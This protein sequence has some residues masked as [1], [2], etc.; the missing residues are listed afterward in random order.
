MKKE[1]FII[2]KWYVSTKWS[3]FIATKFK[4]FNYEGQYT[5]SEVIRGKTSS[6]E[7][8]S[9]YTATDHQEWNTFKEI[10]LAEI[11]KYLPVGHADLNLSSPEY[12]ICI[13]S[14]GLSDYK[15]NHIYKLNNGKIE[16]GAAL[17]RFNTHRFVQTTKE[18]YD[19]QESKLKPV[20]IVSPNPEY[21]KCIKEYAGGGKVGVVY[22]RNGWH[23]SIEGRAIA[24]C[25]HDNP[26]RLKWFIPAT[27]EEYDAQHGKQPVKSIY[28]K[29]LRATKNAESYINK[30]VIYEFILESYDSIQVKTNVTVGHLSPGNILF[31]SSTHFVEATKEQYEAQC[32]PKAVESVDPYTYELCVDTYVGSGV[33]GR[34]YQRKGSRL[35]YDGNYEFD[36]S[37]IGEGRRLYLRSSNKQTY[38]SQFKSDPDIKPDPQWYLCSKWTKTCIAKYNELPKPNLS[39]QPKYIYAFRN[40]QRIHDGSWNIF[41]DIRLA[42]TQEKYDY[43]PE[44]H[45]DRPLYD[46]STL[47]VKDDNDNSSLGVFEPSRM[48]P[49]DYAWNSMPLTIKDCYSSALEENPIIMQN[50]KQKRKLII[51]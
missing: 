7:Y 31:T 9:S 17:W 13:N 5:F 12:V 34:V 38:D 43:L 22:K 16:G 45:P 48:E 14:N 26:T 42:T 51:I 29:Y 1:D 50:K 46:P 24:T 15:D 36:C 37:Q 18:A 40:H 19:A 39:V 30:D 11:T 6:H 21:E 8:Y 4:G 32:K 23:L 47:V 10:P 27:K 49:S 3:N 25:S 41:E 20:T 28:S 2:G 35:Y 33:I 44:G